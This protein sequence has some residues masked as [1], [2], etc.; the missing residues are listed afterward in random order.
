MIGAD[1]STVKMLTEQAK[2]HAKPKIYVIYYFIY[3]IVYISELSKLGT[4]NATFN[5]YL[6]HT[7]VRTSSLLKNCGHCNTAKYTVSQ[8]VTQELFSSRLQTGFY[9]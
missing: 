2:Q 3:F 5:C 4:K 7:D 6:E 9:C 8:H 1:G